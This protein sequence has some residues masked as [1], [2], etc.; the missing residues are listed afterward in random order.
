M[1][2]DERRIEARALAPGMYVC[3]LDRPWE[4]TPFR[5]QGFL[6]DSP[7]QI[8]WVG[9]NCK[10][11]WIDVALGIGPPDVARS[12]VPEAGLLGAFHYRNTADFVEELP[13]A[14]E[15]LAETACAAASLIDAIAAGGAVDAAEVRE[16]VQ[17][18]VQSI[19][20]N[21]DTLFWVNTLRA[22]A[23][24]AYSHAINCSML[25]AAF[26]R[27]LGLP[28]ELLV[29]LA[30]G[31]LLLDVGKTRLPESLVTRPTALAPAEMARVREHVLQGA[32]V[33]E[34]SGEHAPEVIEMVRTHHER[35]DGTGYPRR[36]AGLEIPLYGRIAAIVDCFDA[37][38]TPRPWAAARSRHQALQEIY[39]LGDAAFQGELVEQFISCLGAFPTGSLVE[40]SNGQVAV[41]MMQNPSRRLRPRVM[42][43][44]DSCK[45]LLESFEP[46]DLMDQP[47]D[48]P[49]SEQL[50]VVCGLPVGAHGLDPAE[51]YL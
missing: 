1:Q 36:L 8:K 16:A 25:A 7:D 30:G 48:L 44:T 51:L 46:V 50:N 9:E 40:L 41:V 38:T 5:L 29:D 6:A 28:A 32:E 3:R 42:L 17:P 24:Y 13:Q 2:L 43:L 31:G 12:R 34:S 49:L 14:R 23:G 27:H 11:V 33:L 45:R 20:R 10:S 39:S 35:W 21:S 22:S 19:L 4:G 18:V 26:G 47:E 37:M 15:A